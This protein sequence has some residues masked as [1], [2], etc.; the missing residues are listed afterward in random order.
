MRK[1]IFGALV[2]FCA[3]VAATSADVVT[4]ID[5]TLTTATN[6]GVI[7]AGEYVGFGSGINAGFGDVYGRNSRLYVDSSIGG[8]LNFGLQAGP[9][10][11]NDVGVIYID[12]VP[13]GF[14]DTTTLSDTADPGRRAISGL[15]GSEIVFAP[16]FQA[17]F[18]IAIQPTFAGLFKLNAGGSGSLGFLVSANLDGVLGNP[19]E[20]SL[21]MADIGLIAGNSFRY[22]VTY[23]NTN[24]DFRSDEFHGVASFG[25]GNPGASSVT[26]A[27]GDF[28]TFQ[29]IP[30]P[31]AFLFGGVASILAAVAYRRRK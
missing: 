22:L 23:T 8:A 16:T 25:P 30:E 31:G 24:G 17:D 2:A 13:G 6:D 26:L 4:I 15:G 7:G 18:A 27:A 10:A 20:M 12:S 28:N 19:Y 11:Y 5:T 9:G 14:S 1:L 3:V 29:S 21:T